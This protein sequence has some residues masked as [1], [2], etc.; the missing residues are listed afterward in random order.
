MHLKHLVHSE[1]LVHAFGALDA[2]G[3]LGTLG[4]LGA[5]TCRSIEQVGQGMPRSC[6]RKICASYVWVMHGIGNST[7]P[8]PVALSNHSRRRVLRKLQ[9]SNQYITLIHR[10]NRTK[11][12]EFEKRRSAYSLADESRE[13]LGRSVTTLHKSV[14][15]E[16][17]ES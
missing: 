6:I 5:C 12:Q 7:L 1:H 4:A 10:C 3:A 17:Y 8:E 16:A 2:F 9:V 15:V 11:R 13:V 14:E